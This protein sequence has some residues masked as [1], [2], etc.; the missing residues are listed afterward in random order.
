MTDRAAPSGTPGPV[1]GSPASEPAPTMLA[2]MPTSPATASG[3]APAGSGEVELDLDRLR[4]FCGRTVQSMVEDAERLLADFQG[5]PI[6]ATLFSDAEVGRQFAAQHRAAFEIHEATM[7][8]AVA[9]V[10]RLQDNLRGCVETYQR[11]DDATAEA[12][13]RISNRMLGPGSEATRA[14]DL[15]VIARTTPTTSPAPTT[16]PA[17]PAAGPPATVEDAGTELG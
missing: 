12:L 10:R 15:A 11:E 17:S 4:S 13:L 1:V 2:P 6:S 7:R 8:G 3:A 14:H 16:T 5:A 9:D